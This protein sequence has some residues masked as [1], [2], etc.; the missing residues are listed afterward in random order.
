MLEAWSALQSELAVSLGH[1]LESSMDGAH[2]VLYSLN[3][4]KT[5]LDL[6]KGVA[7]ATMPDGPEK[8][9]FLYLIER[10]LD[11]ASQRNTFVHGEIWHNDEGDGLTVH[12]IRPQARAYRTVAAL[13]EVAL[14]DHIVKVRLREA[15]LAIANAENPLLWSARRLRAPR[16]RRA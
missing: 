4:E 7:R 14:K 13:D 5:R 16:L 10:L 12:S 2:A 6:V 9:G 15:Q 8:R 11:L 1:L 3:S